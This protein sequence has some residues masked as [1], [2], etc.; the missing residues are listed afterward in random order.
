MTCSIIR[1]YSPICPVIGIGNIIIAF[2]T[3]SDQLD[4]YIWKTYTSIVINFRLMTS[5]VVLRIIISFILFVFPLSIFI[6]E[7]SSKEYE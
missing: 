6:P 7:N 5:I 2:Y 3:K 4:E 1:Y